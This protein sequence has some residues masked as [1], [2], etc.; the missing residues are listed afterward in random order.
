MIRLLNGDALAMLRT[1]PSESVHCVVTSPPYWGLRDYGVAGQIGL[2]QSLGQHIDALVG[3]FREVR[4]V[5]RKDGTVWLNYGD[6]YA[7]APNG[8]SAADT[9]VLGNDDRTFRDKPISTVGPIYDPAG[10]AKGGGPRGENKGAGNGGEALPNG[11]IVAGGVL[12]PKDRML[13]PARIAIALQEDGWWVR[14]EIIWHKPNPMPISVRD[15]TTPAHEMVYLLSKAERYFYDQE[16]I[17][18]PIAETSKAR[19]AQ[20]T[21]NSQTGGFKQ[22]MYESGLVGQRSRS[23]RPAEILKTLAGQEKRN[24]RS[25]W[26]LSTKP[27]SGAHFATFPPDLIRPMILAGCPVGGTVLDPF[28]GAGTTGLVAQELGRNAI[29]IELSEA[30]CG[31]IRKRLNLLPAEIEEA[32][33]L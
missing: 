20:E 25:V 16:A 33:A 4:R 17:K 22:E 14:D 19:Y 21:L 7:C 18:E 1:L 12:K 26:S 13:L 11:R 24:R 5:L 28:G 10:G 2:E 6:A 23:R 8:R 3:V 15:R 29:L 31:I 9:K 27:F 30:Y 32:L